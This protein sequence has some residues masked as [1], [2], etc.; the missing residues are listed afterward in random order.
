MT[1]RPQPPWPQEIQLEAESWP[2]LIRIVRAHVQDVWHLHGRPPNRLEL[3]ADLS[4][5]LPTPSEQHALEAWLQRH[6]IH[7]LIAQGSAPPHRL[8][9]E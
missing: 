1:P 9:I 2:A 7:Y 6:R 3:I 8:K 4:L 5:G